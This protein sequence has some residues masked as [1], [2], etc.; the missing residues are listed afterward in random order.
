MSYISKRKIILKKLNTLFLP[1][2][3]K[4]LVSFFGIEKSVYLVLTDNELSPRGDYSNSELRALSALSAVVQLPQI[5]WGNLSP[6]VNAGCLALQLIT[7]A[8]N[9]LEL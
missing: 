7:S 6:P 1:N 3:N 5:T 2:G 4:N 8:A 9:I